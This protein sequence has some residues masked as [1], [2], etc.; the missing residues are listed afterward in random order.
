MIVDT[1]A[2]LAILLEE[3]EAARFLELIATSA[4]SESALGTPQSS[5]L[6]TVL[7]TH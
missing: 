1:S 6:V 3:R 5:T 7:P 2:L 4:T